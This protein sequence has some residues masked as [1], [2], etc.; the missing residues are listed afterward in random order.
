MKIFTFLQYDDY[1]YELWS[2]FAFMNVIWNLLWYTAHG[3]YGCIMIVKV[4]E[5]MAYGIIYIEY[6]LSQI[7]I[8]LIA[9]SFSCYLLLLTCSLNANIYIPLKDNEVVNYSIF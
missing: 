8:L 5:F 6:Y 4:P 1:E 9:P 2:K 7:S 3:D